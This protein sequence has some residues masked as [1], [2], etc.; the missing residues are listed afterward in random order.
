[1][2]V[3]FHKFETEAEAETWAYENRTLF[4]NDSNDDKMFLEALDFYTASA[5]V[6]INN[7][8][9]YNICL[10]ED[11]PSVSYAQILKRKLHKYHI[12]DNII[13][14]RYISKELLDIMKQS[15]NLQIHGILHDKGFMSTTLIRKSVDAY[16]KERRQNILLIIS[17]TAG[18]P[19][20]CV[21]NLKNTLR[22]Y[23]VIL[24]QDTRLRVDFK[25]PFTNRW[26]WCTVV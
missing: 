9:R 19:G 10:D 12:P 8:L 23:E 4:P 25:I 7:Y 26:I 20:T 11:D 14:Y 15:D 13:V 21:I 18:T 2:N 3:H 22:E 5:N 6:P 16:R 1:M 24:A 17:V